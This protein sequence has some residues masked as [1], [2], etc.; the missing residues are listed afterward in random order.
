M[1]IQTQIYRWS[2]YRQ[3][4]F[5]IQ[6][7]T[8]LLSAPWPTTL[9]SVPRSEHLRGRKVDPN[10]SRTQRNISGIDAS[11]QLGGEPDSGRKVKLCVWQE[12]RKKEII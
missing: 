11:N 4:E 12:R 1:L 8:G 2:I 10:V 5:V 6:T 9:T 3:L 7:V